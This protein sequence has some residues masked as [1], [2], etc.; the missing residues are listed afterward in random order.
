[1][2]HLHSAQAAA[3]A[4]LNSARSFFAGRLEAKD[5]ADLQ[6]PPTLGAPPG[7]AMQEHL[8]AAACVAVFNTADSST[9]TADW[10]PTHGPAPPPPT[11]P[12]STA[13]VLGGWRKFEPSIYLTR[14]TNL[15]LVKLAQALYKWPGLARWRFLLFDYFDRV[16]DGCWTRRSLVRA[17]LHGMVPV[18]EPA[19]SILCHARAGLARLVESTWD[20]A[21][22]VQLRFCWEHGNGTD[23]RD[24]LLQ[25]HPFYN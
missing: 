20:E 18:D 14:A 5:A 2:D 6:P 8:P 23:G 17:F 19:D 11:H 25:S 21:R 24:V 7:T 10:R 16:G 1:M 3:A 9:P 13:I 4:V 22:I 12:P 15:A